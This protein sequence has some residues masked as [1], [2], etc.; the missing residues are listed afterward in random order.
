MYSNW[1]CGQV[2]WEDYSEAVHL[3]REKIHAANAELALANT[4]EDSKK[5]FFSNTLTTKGRPERMLV[6]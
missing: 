2:T 3:G 1:K 4:V 5:V 6:C